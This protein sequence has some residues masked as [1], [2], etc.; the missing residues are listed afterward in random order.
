[1]TICSKKMKTIRRGVE[2]T[3]KENRCSTGEYEK[4]EQ[5]IGKRRRR[6]EKENPKT[7][8]IMQRGRD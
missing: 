7:R 4:E 3:I 2:V 1:M 8:W 6:M 5:E